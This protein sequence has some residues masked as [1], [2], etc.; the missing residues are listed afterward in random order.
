M[1]KLYKYTHK[2]EKHNNCLHSSLAYKIKVSK[3]LH[4]AS[5][6]SIVLCNVSNNIIYQSL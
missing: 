6:D 1:N 2:N 4:F 3:Q 5:N